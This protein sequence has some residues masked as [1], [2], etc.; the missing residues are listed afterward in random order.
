MTRQRLTDAQVRELQ[1]GRPTALSEIAQQLDADVLI[2][3]QAR[4]TKQTSD[5]LQVR[6]IAEAINTKGGQSIGRAVVDVPPP[7]EKTAINRSTR[8]LAR[9][10]M[11]DMIQT[12]AATPPAP[13]ETQ[14]A[15]E[16]APAPAPER[17]LVAPPPSP[18]RSPD[19]APVTVPATQP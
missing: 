19:P 18:T 7:L 17:T 6:I 3:V 10:L 4:P 2:Q 1:E 8:F 5:G 16:P 9:K 12:W 14:R 13:R 15:V 11:D